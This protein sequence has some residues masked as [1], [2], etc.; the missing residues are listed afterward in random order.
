[1][2][3]Q[4]GNE[5]VVFGFKRPS[6]DASW[7]E[8][9]QAL[10]AAAKA[11]G[12]RFRMVFLPTQDGVSAEVSDLDELFFDALRDDPPSEFAALSNDTRIDEI[13]DTA[14]ER[15]SVTSDGIE[16]KGTGSVSVTLYSGEGD[17]I[18]M[19]SVPITFEG[20]IN[21]ERKLELHYVHPDLTVWYGE[22][23]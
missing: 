16:I 5:T 13:T 23:A 22:A 20:T 10:R 2:V 11:M 18:D 4:R 8:Q 12:A 15:V 17:A 7:K 9:V 19:I 1:M 3:A 21:D 6:V 14:V